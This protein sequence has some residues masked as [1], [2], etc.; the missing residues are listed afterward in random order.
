MSMEDETPAPVPPEDKARPALGADLIIPV[1][2]AGFTIYFLVS[3]GRFTWEAKANGVVIGVTLLAL[4]AM[5]VVRIFASVRRGDGTLGLGD[6]AAPSTAQG[7]RI[8]LIVILALFVGTISWLG[9]TL[10][11]FLA[12]TAS[13]FVLGVRRPAELFGVP[14]VTSVVVYLVFVLLLPTRMPLG[15]VENGLAALAGGGG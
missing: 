14:L 2:A 15:L 8:A 4:L 11:L 3:T 6:I 12:M 10:A 13:M 7:Q 9:T 1:L 5:Q